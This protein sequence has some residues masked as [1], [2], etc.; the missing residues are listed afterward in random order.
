MSFALST[1]CFIRITSGRDNPAHAMSQPHSVLQRISNPVRKTISSRL[2]QLGPLIHCDA[3]HSQIGYRRTSRLFDPYFD[4]KLRFWLEY[5]SMPRERPALLPKQNRLLESLD[6]KLRVA[7][8]RRRLTTSQFAERSGIS[9]S[10][11]YPREKGEA[12]SSLGT[13]VDAATRSPMVET[14]RQAAKAVEGFKTVQ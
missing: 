3:R 6:E 2:T 11:L 1:K 9:R 5:P 13:H 8:K 10:P 7:R 4:Q 12:S 14:R